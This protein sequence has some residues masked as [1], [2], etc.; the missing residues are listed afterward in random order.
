MLCRSSRQE[1]KIENDTPPGRGSEIRQVERRVTC[2][3]SYHI[4]WTK[5]L[6]SVTT[7]SNIGFCA[8]RKQIQHFISKST[9]VFIVD[10][11]LQILEQIEVFIYPH[12]ICQKISIN[13]KEIIPLRW[14]LNYRL[15]WFFFYENRED[16]RP[17]HRVMHT[18]YPD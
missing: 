17:L 13:C 3:V 15:S 2:F 7:R 11:N 10:L 4:S 6:R 14:L 12:K 1:I 5:C 18:V 16:P 8:N 9:N